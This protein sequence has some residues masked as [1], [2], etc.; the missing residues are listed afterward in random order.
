M[1]TCDKAIVDSC[2]VGLVR[3][4]FDLWSMPTKVPSSFAG[5]TWIPPLYQRIEPSVFTW[6]YSNRQEGL[7]GSMVHIP[8]N[9]KKWMFGILFVFLI[10][11]VCLQ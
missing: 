10:L 7:D 1:K 2:A 9:P 5:W 6:C 8:W 11:A 3:E 4:V